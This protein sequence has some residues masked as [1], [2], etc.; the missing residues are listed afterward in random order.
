MVLVCPASGPGVPGS[1]AAPGWLGSG[2]LVKRR[3]VMRPLDRTR[4]G[5]HPV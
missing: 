1:A 3:V 4:F 2:L 5:G